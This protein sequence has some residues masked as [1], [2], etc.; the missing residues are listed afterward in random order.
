[1]WS[2]PNICNAKKY[3]GL[4]M[5]SRNCFSSAQGLVPTIQDLLP[6]AEHRFCMRHLYANFRKRFSG[7]KIKDTHVEGC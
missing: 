4:Q 2:I 7:K 1:M 3:G 6:T 5:G